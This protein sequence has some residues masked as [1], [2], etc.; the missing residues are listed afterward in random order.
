MRWNYSEN[1]RIR[2]NESMAQTNKS[3]FSFFAFESGQN[4]TTSIEK[5]KKV[6]N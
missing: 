1:K 4:E 5:K 2:L 6:F 3:G